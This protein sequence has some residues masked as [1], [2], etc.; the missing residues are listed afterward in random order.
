MRVLVAGLI[1]GIVMFAWGVAAHMALGLGNVGIQ[2]PA[3]ENV[4]LNSLHEG[5]G[6]QPGV[7]I[8]P[9]LDPKRMGDEAVL[10][11]YSAKAA[12]SPY[13]FVV[14][15]PQGE[16]MMQMGPQIG[17]QWA[18]DTLAALALA[19]VLGL[20]GLGF[21]RRVVLAAAAAVFAWLCTVVPY[22]NWY[23]FPLDF[24]LAALVEQLVGWL[25]AGA[26]MAW[27]LGRS[28]RRMAS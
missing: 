13:A 14:Y 28:E 12:T 20:A 22:W 5:L 26:A 9:S 8:L 2:M 27:W 1:G 10:K 11:A 17:R 19:F 4:V 7:Y 16:D 23:R 18:S 6:N 24:T 3:D 15:L 21:R 25:L